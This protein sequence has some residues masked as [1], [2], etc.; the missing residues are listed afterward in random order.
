MT[1]KRQGSSYKAEV[2]LS[3]TYET[4]EYDIVIEG[5][6]DGI[7]DEPG[8]IPMIDE[9]KGTFTKLDKFEE[10][11]LLHVAQVDCYACIYAKQHD[12]DAIK[13]RV[14]Y[15]HLETEDIK[16]FEYQTIYRKREKI[17]KK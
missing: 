10:P 5:R 14:T 12:L 13:V 2:P 7:V 11:D 17:A 4:E 3:Y 1:Q 15:I 8:E 16:I 9:I 6:A